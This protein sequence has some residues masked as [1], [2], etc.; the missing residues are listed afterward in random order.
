MGKEHDLLNAG[1]T[2]NVSQIEKIL[3]HRVKKSGLQS[4]MGRSVNPNFQD[5][6]GYTPLHYASLHGHRSAVELLLKYDASALIPDHSGNYPLHLA[7]FNGHADVCRILIN[8]GPSRADVNEQNGTKDTAMHSAA[9]SKSSQVVAV[10]LENHADPFLRNCRKESALDLAAQYG[11]MEN[12]KLLLDYHPNLLQDH[13]KT[14]SPLH[15]AARNG[16]IDVVSNLLGCGMSVNH[17]CDTGT[18]LHEAALFGKLDVCNFLLQCDVDI[19]VKDKNQMTVMDLLMKHPS[20]KTKE[21][22]T[23]IYK[24]SQSKTRSKSFKGS[25]SSPDVPITQGSMPSRSSTMINRQ[26]NYDDIPS[27]RPVSGFR[28]CG[29]YDSVPA[30]KT[31]QEIMSQMSYGLVPNPQSRPGNETSYVENADRETPSQP[32]I[33]PSAME[34]YSYVGTPAQQPVLPS[35][36]PALTP[37]NVKEGYAVLGIPVVPGSHF[38][39]SQPLTGEDYT[40]VRSEGIAGS[41][42]KSAMKDS[43]A[44]RQKIPTGGRAGDPLPLQAMVTKENKAYYQIEP[45]TSGDEPQFSAM[46]SKD[47]EVVPRVPQRRDLQIPLYQ[48]PPTFKQP[49]QPQPKPPQGDGDYGF[50]GE[51]FYKKPEKPA[52]QVQATSPMS[53]PVYEIPP[54]FKSKQISSGDIPGSQAKTCPLDIPQYELVGFRKT[55]SEMGP[56]T[57]PMSALPGY[58]PMGPETPEN[59][60]GEYEVFAPRTDASDYEVLPRGAIL[61]QQGTSQPSI[62]QSP[63]VYEIAPPPRLAQEEP[64]PTPSPSTLSQ[65]SPVYEIAPPPRPCVPTPPQDVVPIVEKGSVV[66][67]R[68]RPYNQ[69]QVCTVQPTV[70]GSSEP[71]TKQGMPAPYEQVRLEAPKGKL[72]LDQKP[73]LPPRTFE[74]DYCTLDPNAMGQINPPPLPS[75]DNISSSSSLGSGSGSD[76]ADTPGVPPPSP[77]MAASAVFEA[78]EPRLQS[79]EKRAEKTDDKKPVSAKRTLERRPVPTPR[80]DSLHDK[81]KWYSQED[82]SKETGKLTQLDREAQDPFSYPPTNEKEKIESPPSPEKATTFTSLHKIY[83]PFGSKENLVEENEEKE[84]KKEEH[85][86]S[87]PLLYENVLFKRSD[88]TVRKSI[89]K[90]PGLPAQENGGG[91]KPDSQPKPQLSDLLD[92]SDTMDEDA[93]W[94][95]IEALLMSISEIEMPADSLENQIADAVSGEATSVPE[96]LKFLGMSQYEPEFMNNGFDNLGFLNGGV[97]ADLDL[98]E[99]GVND[100][101]DRKIILEA[102]KSL[103]TPPRVA[104]LPS[105]PSTVEEWLASLCLS[106]YLVTL[107]HHGYTTM[108]R[109]KQMWEVELTSVLEINLIGHRNRILASLVEPRRMTLARKSRKSEVY[110][111]RGNFGLD[112]KVAELDVYCPNEEQPTGVSAKVDADMLMKIAEEMVHDENLKKKAEKMKREN[113][114]RHEPAVLLKGSVNYSAQYLGSQTVRE[115]VGVSSTVEASRKM[116]MSTAKLQKIPSVILAVS[117]NGIKF[118]DARTKFVVSNHQMCNV[119]YITQ[120]PEDKRVFAYIAKDAKVNKHYCHVFRV[121]QTQLSDEITM[122]IGQAF[123]LAYEQFMQIQDYLRKNKHQR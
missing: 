8:S 73:V 24:H 18:A 121:D 90:K 63:P 44:S 35:S 58:E 77:S 39:G 31:K 32:T 60:F 78:L 16:H 67:P 75:R 54:S 45:H 89:N 28:R 84:I 52:V 88:S 71:P 91:T 70:Q 120:D 10:L 34:V 43:G 76:L 119:S 53:P 117:V 42:G 50:V 66:P 3:G 99:I 57:L 98:D 30:P 110:D 49:P 59:P 104:K 112:E 4:I 103:P 29:T 56:E 26:S 21:I 69:Y 2:G 68:P 83:S 97:L 22:S 1:K 20:S 65:N 85:E 25:S 122:T 101:A 74:G 40:A 123:E 107:L 12:V 33:Q 48:T 116:R 7:A 111:S 105:P 100:P 5:E 106:E 118:I 62:A 114:W 79:P 36:V 11:R 94:E 80:R 17:Q 113:R 55:P 109:V 14:H 51:A 19:S 23:L 6:M 108:D 115:I 61:Q 9:Q 102:V 47:Y 72:N 92:T 86:D 27:P 96:W 38:T 64:Q 95:K 41:P 82:Q 46:N 81:P 87:S 93:E 13:I 15:L 37:R